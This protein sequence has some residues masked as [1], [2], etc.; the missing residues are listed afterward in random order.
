MILTL[1]A[2]KL[3]EFMMFLRFQANSGEEHGR[4]PL[5]HLTR[6]QCDA[7]HFRRIG[8]MRDARDNGAEDDGCDDHLPLL[9][10]CAQGIQG[11]PGMAGW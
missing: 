10:R 7:A 2:A 1:S 11:G 3:S 8:H 6:L 4:T 5:H 9:L